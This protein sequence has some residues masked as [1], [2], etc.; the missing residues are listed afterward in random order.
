MTPLNLLGIACA[1]ALGGQKT[2]PPAVFTPTVSYKTIRLQGFKVR[3]SPEAQDAKAETGEALALLKRK[4]AEIE[5]L[6]PKPHLKALRKVAFWIER[7]SR[8]NGA[9]EFHNSVEWLKQN[10]Y[11]PDKMRSVEIG[12][13]RNFV[14][15][16]AEQPL[17]VLHELA[18]SYH[19]GTLGEKNPEVRAAFD[20]A[21]KAGLYQEVSYIRGGKK[22]RAYALTNEFEYFAELTEAYFGQ[23]DFFP[24][25]REDLRTYDPSGYALMERVWS[26][27]GSKTQTEQGETP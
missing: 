23:N 8:P 12:N 19:F 16:H 9:A 14:K 11:N 25:N 13:V 20:N 4:L 7:E 27:P 2:P 5:T 6:V 10:G 22:Q 15:W 1:L 26:Q 24:F 3:V 21:V 18:H 17:M